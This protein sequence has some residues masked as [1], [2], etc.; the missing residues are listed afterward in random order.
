[1]QVT[2]IAAAALVVLLSPCVVPALAAEWSWDPMKDV[3]NV[4]PAGAPSEPKIL[5]ARQQIQEAAHDGLSAL[6]EA[7]PGA[8]TIIEHAAGYAVFSAFGIKV[9]FAGGTNGKGMVVNNRTH[10]R[11]YMRMVGLQAG[12][13]LGVKKDRLIFVFETQSALNAFINQ[14]WEFGASAS[15][16][17]AADNQGGSLAGAA[18]VSPGVYLYQI[19]STGLAAQITASGTKYFKDDDLN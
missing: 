15:I 8:R 19:T 3:E 10:R 16:A 2:R 17:A 1:M 14:G 6:Y 7:A 18:S 4:L 11:T 13:G 5:Q 12:L 9:F